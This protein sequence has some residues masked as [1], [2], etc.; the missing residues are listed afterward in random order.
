MHVSIYFTLINRCI[1]LY[2][3]IL[4][5]MSM[6]THI[7]MIYD[8]VFKMSEINLASWSIPVLQHFGD[9][10]RRIRSLRESSI[11]D[12]IPGQQDDVRLYQKEK[13]F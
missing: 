13:F 9:S 6:S 1:N 5:Y 2:I 10:G 4:I 8:S 3:C 12:G 7:Y 11:I